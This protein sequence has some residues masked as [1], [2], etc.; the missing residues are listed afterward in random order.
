MPGCRRR[1][2]GCAR[3]ACPAARSP[4]R[5]RPAQT[6]PRTA[7]SLS[8]ADL[9]V[10]AHCRQGGAMQGLVPASPEAIARAAELLRAGKLVAFPT[11]TVYGLGADATDDRAVARIFTA[12][13]RP[14]FNPL[15]VHMPDLAAA[16]AIAEFGTRARNIAQ[17]FWPGPLT[18]VLRRREASGVSL[19]ACT[20]L[21]T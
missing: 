11:E 9:A 20:G 19:L 15:I 12:K 2:R 10:A 21:D 5:S 14:R 4:A 1:R 13:G 6:P 7:P 18:L 8:R 17:H 3:R 16:E